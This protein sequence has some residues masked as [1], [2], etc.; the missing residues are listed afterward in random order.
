MALKL[1]NRVQ[2][3][4]ATQNQHFENLVAP[5]KWFTPNQKTT[6]F[7]QSTSQSHQSQSHKPPRCYILAWAP[8]PIIYLTMQLLTYMTIHVGG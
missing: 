1:L 6:E 8:M 7:Y 5:W 3:G 2:L 4:L